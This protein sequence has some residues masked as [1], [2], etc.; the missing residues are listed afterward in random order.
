[1]NNILNMN[2]HFFT[3]AMAF[4]LSFISCETA[5]NE[6]ELGIEGTTKEV[7]TKSITFDAAIDNEFIG[8]ALPEFT[9]NIFY[10]FGGPG[11]DVPSEWKD[12]TEAAMARWEEL[13]SIIPVIPEV[14]FTFF[15]RTSNASHV[16][17]VAISYLPLMNIGRLSPPAGARNPEENG[18]VGSLIVI[19]SDS[20]ISYTQEDR[21]NIM[22]SQITKILGQQ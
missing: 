12:A 13:S 3:L 20:L 19:N 9:D 22:F 1:M 4:S 16:P 17:D 11:A 6:D 8:P 14:N 18:N 2:K 21:E 15:I 5:S 7:T 10:T